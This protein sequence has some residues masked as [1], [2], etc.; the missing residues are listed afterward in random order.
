MRIAI[1]GATGFVGKELVSYLLSHSIRPRILVRKETEFPDVDQCMGDA[2]TGMGLDAFTQGADIV[3]NLIG[4]FGGAFEALMEG[5]VFATRNLCQSLLRNNIKKYIHMSSA[6]VYGV[7]MIDNAPAE[8]EAIHPDTEY[9]LSKKMGEDTVRVFSTVDRGFSYTILRP[10]NIYG[11]GAI[12]GTIYK[13]IESIRNKNTIY[14]TGDGTQSRDFVHVED[15]CRLIHTLIRA[16][17]IHEVINV[18]SGYVYT[19]NELVPFFEAAYGHAI[20]LEYIPKDSGHVAKLAV[21]AKKMRTL[22]GPPAYTI[23]EGIKTCI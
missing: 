18:G 15:V 21:D 16:P 17:F 3:I 1:A 14:I 20:D 12:S 6:A 19:L 4:K 7:A 9:G 11:P 2:V 5:N 13:F 22:I 23:T 8:S 10:T